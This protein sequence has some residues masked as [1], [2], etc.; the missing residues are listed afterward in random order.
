MESDVAKFLNQAQPLLIALARHEAKGE[1]QP[2]GGPSET[3][4]LKFLAAA[5]AIAIIAIG[6]TAVYLAF[7]STR[8]A[9][10]L[11]TPPAPEPFID[12]TS[13]TEETI[14]SGEQNLPARLRDSGGLSKPTGSFHRMII[15]LRDENGKSTTMGSEVFFQTLGTTPPREFI[16]SIIDPPQLFLYYGAAGPHF[17]MIF[18]THDPD[19]AIGALSSWE[20]LLRHDLTPIFFGPLPGPVIQPYAEVS[21]KNID[22]RYL[23]LAPDRD[24]GLGYLHFPARRLIVIATSEEMIRATITRLLESRSP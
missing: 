23:K 19:R 12:Y 20:P 24:V 3:Q 22:F 2:A 10:T 7:R 15:Q 6:G 16:A 21:Y 5:F 13:V 9:P 14:E 8:P 1:E 4:R 18:K 17:G 11:P